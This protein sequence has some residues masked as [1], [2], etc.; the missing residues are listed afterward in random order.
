[1]SN[2]EKVNMKS[3]LDYIRDE[4]GFEWTPLS[5]K[6]STNS[7]TL[8]VEKVFNGDT[9]EDDYVITLPDN[10]LEQSGW[11]EGDM[12]EWIDNKDGSFILTK[13]DEST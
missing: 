8:P 13:C 12:L 5:E 1:M 6:Y 7:Y 4:G 10:L 3:E 2:P 11:K 9:G